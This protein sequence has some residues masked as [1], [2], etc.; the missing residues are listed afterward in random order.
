MVDTG[1]K[2]KCCIPYNLTYINTLHKCCIPMTFLQVTFTQWLSGLNITLWWS[3][4]WKTDTL[5][6]LWD[7]CLRFFQHPDSA[8]YSLGLIMICF[9]FFPSG[10]S[11]LNLWQPFG[12]HRFIKRP[13]ECAVS[14]CSEH[15]LITRKWHKNIRK[16][17]TVSG[18]RL[19][20]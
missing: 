5:K 13:S 6:I 11:L 10:K 7:G 16:A 12:W 14:T 19:I 15:L 18:Q 17:A 4:G 1:G 2:Y 9:M 3:L 8:L 20:K